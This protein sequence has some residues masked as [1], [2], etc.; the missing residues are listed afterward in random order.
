MQYRYLGRTGLRVSTIALGTATFGGT[1]VFSAMGTTDV[2]GATRLVDMCVDAGVN[3]IDTA[4]TYSNGLSEEI[5]GK[6][7][8]GKRDR[9]L[10]ATKARGLMGD[11]PNDGGT[12]RHHIIDQCEKSLKRLGVDHIDLYQLHNWDGI[13]APEE[14]LSALQALQQAGKI[15][16]FGVSNYTGWQLMKSL[17][18]SA[19]N[20][21]PKIVSQQIYYSLENRDCENEMIPVAIDQ[22]L[23]VLIWSPLA[24]GLL[25]GKYRRGAAGPA[26]AR[27]VVGWPEP[28]DPDMD[29]IHRI[30]EGLDTVAARNG[31][32]VPQAALAYLLAK[33]AVTSLIVGAKNETQLAQNLAAADVTLSEDD[34]GLLDAL[35]QQRL[36]YPHWHHALNAKDRLGPADLAMLGRHIKA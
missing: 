31:C 13:T 27:H 19:V 23:G 8:R 7:V 30:V 11:G 32:S 21:L 33:P 26:G 34:V 4:N 36:N 17:M 10:I 2:A 12:S 29:R 20:H 6:A 3:L 25:S 14:T 1:G 28:P 22:G 9:L 5:L 16:Y 18:T 35:S 15:R 24:G